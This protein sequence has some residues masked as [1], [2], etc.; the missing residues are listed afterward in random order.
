MT[1]CFLQIICFISKY[2]A[3]FILRLNHDIPPPSLI[4]GLSQSNGRCTRAKAEKEEL[5]SENKMLRE[6]LEN[7][8]NEF[9]EKHFKEWL[10]KDLDRR[11]AF[12]SP[13]THPIDGVDGTG[14]AEGEKT[15]RRDQG[16][17]IRKLQVENQTLRSQ[18]GIDV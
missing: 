13:D 18:V 15:S 12:L 11:L 3:S 5:R 1:V 8:T 9:N 10:E 4:S 16:R 14:E 17:T 2:F 6:S 7:M